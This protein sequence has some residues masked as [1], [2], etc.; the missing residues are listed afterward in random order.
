MSYQQYVILTL[1][2]ADKGADRYTGLL[3]FPIARYSKELLIL[4]NLSFFGATGLDWPHVLTGN[5]V[6]NNKR[7]DKA[8]CCITCGF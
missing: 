7:T 4:H 3:T 6:D 5:N 2:L 1:G 8:N